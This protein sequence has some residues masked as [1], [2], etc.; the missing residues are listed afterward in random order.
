MRPLD[1]ERIRRGE[2][3]TTA[4]R[5]GR[6]LI[7]KDAG[8]YLEPFIFSAAGIETLPVFSFEEE[9][10]TFLWLAG[11]EGRW[12]TRASGCGELVSLLY[13][14]C[15]RVR[16]VALDPLPGMVTDGTVCLVSVGRDRFV[17]H[18]LGRESR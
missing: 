3:P 15:G 16:S 12:L 11:L 5:A 6:W 2:R 14:P 4:Q 1:Q 8:G 17:R 9:A 18:L 10:E 13:G 7:A